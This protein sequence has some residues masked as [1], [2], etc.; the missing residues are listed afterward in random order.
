VTGQTI[1]LS[2]VP[3]LVALEQTLL[4]PSS[5]QVH[6]ERLGRAIER[7]VVYDVLPGTLAD[8]DGFTLD[9]QAVTGRVARLRLRSHAVVPPPPEPAAPVTPEG[10]A[11][12][13]AEAM[14][15]NAT[16]GD[17][18][19]EEQAALRLSSSANPAWA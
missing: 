2:T 8:P 7:R 10:P 13:G 12:E 18:G 1:D 15:V 9:V 16:D 6:L 4:V 11:P 19:E 5:T 14:G 17:G 3:L